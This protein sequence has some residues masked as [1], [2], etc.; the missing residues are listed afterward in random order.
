[1]QHL[2]EYSLHTHPN[3]F[4]KDTPHGTENWST[5]PNTVNEMLC[6]GHQG[7]LR[8]FPAWPRSMDASFHTIRV[9]GAFLV[10][11]SLKG[12]EIG[13]VTILSEQGRDLKM[14]NPWPGKDVEIRT[15]DRGKLVV[16][17]GYLETETVKGGEYRLRP[18]T[19]SR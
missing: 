4:Q 16:R 7:T 5:V 12:G 9:E 2:H 18:V 3:G 19:G 1:M 6:M 14:L 17:G 13:E 8:L 10:S 11:A 15:P